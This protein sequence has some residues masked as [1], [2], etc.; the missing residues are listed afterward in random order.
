MIE[1]VRPPSVTPRENGK[2]PAINYDIHGLV[3]I[4]LLNPSASDA[5]AVQ[6]QL[7][8]PQASLDR[9]PDIVVRFEKTLSTAG[10]RYVGVNESGVTED[11][12]FVLQS[13]RRP[14]KVRIAFEQIGERCEIVCESGLQSVPLLTE[15]LNLTVLKQKCVPLHASAFIH[16]NTGVLVTGWAR[17]GKTEALLAFLKHGAAYVGDEW[18]TLTE[19]GRRMYGLPSD[20]E[21]WERDVNEIPNMRSQVGLQGRVLFAA[22]HWLDRMQA[23]IPARLGRYAPVRLLRGAMYPLRRQLRVR[24]PP[25]KMC[26]GGQRNLDARPD[27]IFLLITHN[28]SAIHIERADPLSVSRR[29][30]FCIRCEQLGLTS[31]YLAFTFARPGVRNPFLETAY[32]LEGR[33]LDRALAGKEAYTV[34]HPYP[35]SLDRLFEAMKPFVEQRA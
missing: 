21:V 34:R 14:A 31:Q 29:M 9:E 33:I 7:G 5:A 35:V 32:R 26:W 25:A 28:D 20:L 11:G 4:R 23:R 30:I 17:C 2:R 24:I 19:D 13:G 12:F 10:I 1:G 6:R 3:G 8:P 16:Q 15:I 18:I 27:K 22:I